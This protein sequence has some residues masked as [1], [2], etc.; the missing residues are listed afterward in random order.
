MT[1]FEGFQRGVIDSARRGVLRF[2][3]RLRAVYHRRHHPQ[4]SGGIRDHEQENNLETLLYSAGGVIAL[5]V[6]LI[7]V[8]FLISAFNARVDL[9]EGS[10]YTLSPGTK[11]IL[12]QARSAGHNPL[13]LLARAAARCRWD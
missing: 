9:T 4:P 10:V 12:V 2:G 13:L 3:D 8:N 7:A 1:H 5:V 11:A 6:I